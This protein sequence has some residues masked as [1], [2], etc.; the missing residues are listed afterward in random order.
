MNNWKDV[1]HLFANGNFKVETFFGVSDFSMIEWHSETQRFLVYHDNK[2]W[3]DLSH[4]T[5]IARKIDDMTYE[6]Y[7]EHQQLI[8]TVR[9]GTHGI[10]LF[11]GE[12]VESFLYLLSIGVYPFDQSHFEDGTVIDIKDYA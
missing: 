3:C 11:R 10:A 7:N 1:P 4:C 6:E 5:L 2:R 9:N 12:S 8:Y